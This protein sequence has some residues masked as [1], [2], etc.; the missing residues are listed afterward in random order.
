M[1]EFLETRLL[2]VYRRRYREY[3]EFPSF[4]P[5]FIFALHSLVAA[6]RGATT[7]RVAGLARKGKS[8]RCTFYICRGARLRNFF[9]VF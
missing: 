1:P 6:Q 9:P 2:E 3:I 5:S 8:S 4:A 7:G